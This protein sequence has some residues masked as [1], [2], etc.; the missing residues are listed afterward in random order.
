MLPHEHLKLSYI[1][2]NIKS[3]DC[4]RQYLAWLNL[5]FFYNLSFTE[6]FSVRKEPT[7]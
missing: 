4:N 2:I 3:K 6:R 1:I 5:F 7:D